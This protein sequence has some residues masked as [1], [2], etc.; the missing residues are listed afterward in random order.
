MDYMAWHQDYEPSI[1]DGPPKSDL[2]KLFASVV[3]DTSQ[4]WM[5]IFITTWIVSLRF[6]G[7]ARLVLLLAQLRLELS[8]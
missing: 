7:G 4:I 2:G 1:V 6:A 3:S 5:T 8:H